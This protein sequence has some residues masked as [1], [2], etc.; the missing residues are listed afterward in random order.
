MHGNQ[1]A[2]SLWRH[3][4][5][6]RQSIKTHLHFLYVWHQLGSSEKRW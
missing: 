5:V 2:N 6:K 4:F 1:N 3:L